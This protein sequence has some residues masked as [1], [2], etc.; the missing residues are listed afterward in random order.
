MKKT[1]PLTQAQ[2]DTKAII[3]K[4]ITATHVVTKPAVSQTAN[5][6]STA[7]KTVAHTTPIK[8]QVAQN[9]PNN[10][11]KASA[12]T[13]PKIIPI[14]LP[15]LKI[16]DLKPKVESKKVQAQVQSKPVTQHNVQPKAQPAQSGVLA[17]S[18]SNYAP[19]V[20]FDSNGRR[21]I[22][23]E[24]RVLHNVQETSKKQETAAAPIA[25]QSQ[26]VK[27]E[28]NSANAQTDRKSVV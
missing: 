20:K 6:Q 15:K 5:P 8:P 22:D 14:E 21:I 23:L 13:T 18:S 2:K 19:K 26:N 27:I 7:Q 12:P 3:A 4:N 1:N 9:K 11:Q 17:D 28:D 10:T 25:G 16:Q 24:P